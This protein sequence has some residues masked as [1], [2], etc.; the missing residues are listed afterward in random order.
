M[1][2]QTAIND[3]P[4]LIAGPGEYATRD[5]RRVTIREVRDATPGTTSFSAV[6]S[7][8]TERR[9]VLRA[10]GHDIWHVSGRHLVLRESARDIVG[11][12]VRPDRAD[13]PA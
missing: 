11:P 1:E 7:V 2:T 6:G 3:L 5:G 8:W 10:R 4:V 9:G 13:R 12:F